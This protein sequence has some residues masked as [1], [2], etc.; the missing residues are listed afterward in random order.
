M[1]KSARISFKRALKLIRDSE[2]FLKK[3]SKSCS[4]IKREAQVF[5][6]NNLEIEPESDVDVHYCT[7]EVFYWN[8]NDIEEFR[9]SLKIFAMK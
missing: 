9:K 4:L 1:I 3:K 5:K 7:T 8:Y 2:K 6:R